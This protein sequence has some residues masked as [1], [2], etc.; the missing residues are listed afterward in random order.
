[1]KCSEAVKLAG[2]K[3]VAQVVTLSNR[4][5]ASIF[6][7]FSDRKFKSKFYDNLRRAMDAKHMQERAVMEAAIIEIMKKD[8]GNDH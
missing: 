5:K 2:F 6:I 1:M 3:S 7:D 8:V 4:S